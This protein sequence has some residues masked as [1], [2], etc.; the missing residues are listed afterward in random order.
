MKDLLGSI[1]LVVPYL[2][3]SNLGGGSELALAFPWALAIGIGVSAI[4]GIL[5]SKAGKKAGQVQ[6]VSG[7]KIVKQAGKFLPKIR[8]LEAIGLFI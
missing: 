3:L 6:G 1:S 2:L 7:K 8:E 5:S 4:G